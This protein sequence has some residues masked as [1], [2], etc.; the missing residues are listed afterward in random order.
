MV[1]YAHPRVVRFNIRCRYGS[2]NLAS[3]VTFT[4]SAWVCVLVVRVLARTSQYRSGV[5]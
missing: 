3:T 2:W 1:W 5:I 4:A